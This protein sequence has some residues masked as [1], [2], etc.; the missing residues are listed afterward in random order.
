M[1][2]SIH[3]SIS[4]DIGID[5]EIDIACMHASTFKEKQVTHHTHMH[6][7][8]HTLTQGHIAHPKAKHFPGT[9]QLKPY[10]VSL[11]RTW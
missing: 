4:I 8:V 9:F 3:L 6:V 2:M 5:S 10:L 7:C 1:F 11:P